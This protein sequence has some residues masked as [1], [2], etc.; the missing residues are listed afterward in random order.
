MPDLNK[1]MLMG[2]LTADPELRR[3]SSG[4]AVTELRMATSRS[5]KKDDEWQKE[6]LY[7]DVVV[8][9][10]QAERCCD[11]LRKGSSVFVEGY[12]KMDTWDDKNTG[13]K[14][15]KI[16]VQADRV[17]FLDGKPNGEDQG[18]QQRRDDYQPQQS[19]GG[20]RQDH[21]PQPQGRGGAPQGRGGGYQGQGRQTAPP[22][23][24][25]E[26]DDDVDIPFSR[27]IEFDSNEFFEDVINGGWK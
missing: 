9:G 25:A 6:T 4:T 19:R 7:I 26:I 15:S 12:L 5:W 16:R 10:A 24:Q 11:Q 13:E 8:W 14:R 18:G 21:A 2:R 27:P 20:T 22:V 1:T 3:I 17:Q 23:S